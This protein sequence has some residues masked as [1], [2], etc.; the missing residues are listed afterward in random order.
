MTDTDGLTVYR[1][2]QLEQAVET[3]AHAA[4]AQAAF[5]TRVESFMASAKTWGK[6]GLLV[7]GAGQS[8]MIGVILYGVQRIG[9]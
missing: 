3:M 1:V 5:N 9:G 2:T 6:V 7:Y 4:D 8:L